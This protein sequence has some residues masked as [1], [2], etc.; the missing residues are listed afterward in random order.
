M[1]H[2]VRYELPR[3][4]SLALLPAGLCFSF[5]IGSQSLPGRS[6]QLRAKIQKKNINTTAVLQSLK[7]KRYCKMAFSLRK[8][9]L[10]NC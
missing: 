3:P 1:K 9:H 7:K 5:K 6:A 4:L 10:H 8:S 2:F